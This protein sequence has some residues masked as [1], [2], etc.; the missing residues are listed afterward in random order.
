MNKSQFDI[1]KTF[2]EGFKIPPTTLVKKWRKFG[3]E[4]ELHEVFRVALCNNYEI[5]KADETPEEDVMLAMMGL[6]K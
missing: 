5:Y 4:L 1:V 6:G 2:L 3:V